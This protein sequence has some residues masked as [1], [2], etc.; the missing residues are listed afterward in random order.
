MPRPRSFDEDRAIDAALRAFWT[1]GYEA[2]STEQLCAATGLGRSSLYNT[3][4]GKRELFERALRRYTER[5]NAALA[6]LLA[7]HGAR[8]G[9]RALLEQVVQA[10]ADDPPGCLVVNTL[11]E[12]APRDPA[13]AAL[14]RADGGLRRDLLAAALTAGQRTG[15]ITADVPATDLATAVITAVTGMRVAARGGATRAELAATARTA[16]RML[17]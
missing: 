17:D 11:V 10:P 12:L 1:A 2:T 14:L 4:T 15:E 7:A 6:E 5:K 13:V 3:F 9:V 16:L 8:A